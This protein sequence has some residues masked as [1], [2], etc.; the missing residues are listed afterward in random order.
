MCYAASQLTGEREVAR[1]AWVDVGL[2]QVPGYICQLH[3]TVLS[4]LGHLT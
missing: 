4:A 3:A 1:A 2:T